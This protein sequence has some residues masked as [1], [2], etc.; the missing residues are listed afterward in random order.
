MKCLSIITICFNDRTG[1]ERTFASVFAQT[2]RAFD[3]IVVDGGSTDG[4]LELIKKNEERIDRWTCETDEGIYDAQNK[5]WRA[6]ST[7]YV[8]FLNAG[9]SLAGPEVLERAL[10]ELEPRTD[11]AYSDLQLSD[12]RG[13]YRTKQYPSQIGSAWLMK[14]SVAHPTQI[15]RRKLFEE[16][17]GLD[18]S[19]SIAADYAFFAQVFWTSDPV[20]QKLTTVISTF[21]TTGVSS[22]AKRTEQL[23]L[24]RNDIQHRYAPRFWYVLYHAYA[25]FNRMIGR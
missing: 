13:I 7:E 23:R 6:A 2:T 24:E 20:L 25:T 15:I 1:L 3:Y 5:G 14:E 22:D 18:Q 9:D 12:T 10:A 21:D 11:I 8:L 17:G 4:S 16:Y 19:Y